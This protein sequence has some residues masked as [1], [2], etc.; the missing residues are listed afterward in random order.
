MFSRSGADQS[1]GSS[2]MSAIV[3]LLAQKMMCGEGI[4]SILSGITSGDNNSSAAGVRIGSKLSGLGGLN[5][6]HELVEHLQ[7]ISVCKIQNRPDNIR[8]MELIY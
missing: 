6:N 1:M 8:S 4:A 7:Q 3:G 2:V 5:K